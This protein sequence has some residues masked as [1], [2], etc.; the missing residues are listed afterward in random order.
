MSI[1][2]RSET[3]IDHPNAKDMEDIASAVLSKIDF[4]RVSSECKSIS[5]SKTNRPH[6]KNRPIGDMIFDTDLCKPLW[7]AGNK[8]WVDSDG[9]TVE[10]PEKYK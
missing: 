4:T 7:Y 2:S 1:S 8:L 5:F 3:V 6:S 9:N 10:N